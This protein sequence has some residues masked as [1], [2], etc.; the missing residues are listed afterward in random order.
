[1]QER[2]N[3]GFWNLCCNYREKIIVKMKNKLIYEI[4]SLVLLCCFMSKCFADADF[5][6]QAAFCLPKSI[7]ETEYSTFNGQC[8]YLPLSGTLTRWQSK[9]TLSSSPV[10]STPELQL[11]A[12]QPSVKKTTKR[13]KRYI[14]YPKT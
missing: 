2:I 4:S 11:T 12:E 1:M 7:V 14:L 3:K 10:R 13:T 6:T 9:M 5:P 8:K